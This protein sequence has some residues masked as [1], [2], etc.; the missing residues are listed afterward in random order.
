[1]NVNKI[2]IQ[3]NQ[4]I[5]EALEILQKSSLKSLIVVN[6]KK[7]LLGILNDAD[8]R[9][10]LLKGAKIETRIS[11][12][13]QDFK[14]IYYV[15]EKKY[16]FKLVKKRIIENSLFIVPIVD[17]ERKLIDC[18][19]FRDKDKKILNT[20]KIPAVIM[21]GGEGVRMRP[22]TNILPKPLL[23]V[24]SKS[25]LEHV[26][27]NFMTYN[28]KNFYISINFKS[29]I[30]KAY[31]KEL[32]RK[33][34]IKIS[35]IT[36]NKPLG[37]CGALKKVEK[38]INSDFFLSNCD[39]LVKLNFHDAYNYHQ[40]NKNIATIIVCK[41]KIKIPYGVIKNNKKKQ[42]SEM[43]EKP[44]YN[45]LVNTGVYILNK[46]VLKNIKKDTFTDMNQLIEKLK[47]NKKKIG[48]FQIN[49]KNWIDVGQWDDYKKSIKNI[50]ELL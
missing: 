20:S 32:K 48:L 45:F 41:K 44:V 42:L 24:N 6:K 28:I 15:T 50:N 25:I 7:K 37:T 38:K 17:I 5:R 26:I 35:N 18:I 27:E 14:N 34:K 8:V 1:M 9:R 29:E 16:D 30:M 46:K 40:K 23:P 33:L 43:L 11:K 4:K 3:P 12:F 39:V 47:K 13:Y 36:E 10:A 49:E 19:T 31:L 2:I 22:F 21:A